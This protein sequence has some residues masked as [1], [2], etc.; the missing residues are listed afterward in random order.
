MNAIASFIKRYPQPVF[1]AIAWAT[2]I[3]GWY[4]YSVTG[5]DMW[6][7]LIFGSALGG[8]FVTAVADGRSGVK[9]YLSRIVRWRVGI[10]WYLVALLLPLVL[11][12][13]ALGLNLLSGARMQVSVPPPAAGDLVFEFLIVFLIIALGEE[14]GFR[15][16]ALPRLLQ[17]RSA[18]TASLILGVLHAIWH[19]PAF[20]LGFEPAIIIPIIIAGAVINTWLFNNTNGSVLL[21]MFLHASVDL[22]VP[23]FNRLFSDAGAQSMTIWLVVAY[24]VTAVLLP[25]FAGRELGRKPAAGMSNMAAAS[26][27]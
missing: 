7:F 23:F 14:P 20:V 17:G 4:M 8:L 19:G 26:G 16:F 11:R 1:W 6:Q 21:A 24:V 10:K 2:S 27:D 22:W 13:V 5:S 3:Y 15:G 9:E 12:L 18:L 25:I